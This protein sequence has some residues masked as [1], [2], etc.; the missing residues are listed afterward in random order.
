MSVLATTVAASVMRDR[1][2][3]IVHRQ[4][5]VG[6]I[7]G[8]LYK[9][10]LDKDPDDE[11]GWRERLCFVVGAKLLYESAKKKGEPELVTEL[12]AIRSVH[13]IFEGGPPGFY[14]FQI[15]R[16]DKDGSARASVFAANSAQE[17]DR[18]IKALLRLRDVYRSS[19]SHEAHV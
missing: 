15:D 11:A 17:R 10:G 13:P 5:A 2:V 18:W 12:V 3:S 4:A 16:T 8:S 19:S 9:L 7:R 1:R 14:L 6:A